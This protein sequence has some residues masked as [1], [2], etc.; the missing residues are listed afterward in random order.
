MI[1]DM[2][3]LFKRD[4]SKERANRTEHSKDKV[5]RTQL[6]LLSTINEVEIFILR[7]TQEHSEVNFRGVVQDEFTQNSTSAWRFNC[8]CI[9]VS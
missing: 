6:E 8:G 2:R 4:E 7:T 1:W 3:E 5:E 9:E